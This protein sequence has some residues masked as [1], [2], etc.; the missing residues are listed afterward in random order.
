MS[1]PMPAPACPS[2]QLLPASCVVQ[3]PVYAA[4]ASACAC[5]C[6]MALSCRTL[7]AQ[8][9]LSATLQG[10]GQQVC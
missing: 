3:S 1:S 9:E 6:A 7:V 10:G 2:N 4:V 8:N 5:M